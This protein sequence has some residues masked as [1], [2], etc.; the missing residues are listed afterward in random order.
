MLQNVLGSGAFGIVMKA[1]AE[2]ISGY[3]SGSTPVAVKFVKG[4]LARNDYCLFHMA[5]PCLFQLHG[6]ILCY[7]C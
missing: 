7:S 5:F 2:E 4:N 1:E 6:V 3:N